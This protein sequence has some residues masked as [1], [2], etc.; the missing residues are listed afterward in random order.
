MSLLQQCC[1]IWQSIIYYLQDKVCS[2][3]LFSLSLS[4][5][6]TFSQYE[7]SAYVNTVVVSKAVSKVFLDIMSV[8]TFALP[9]VSA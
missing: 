7:N 8:I 2:I 3:A 6:T 9:R 4:L 5:K 1:F